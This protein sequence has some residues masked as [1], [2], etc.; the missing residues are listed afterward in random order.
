MNIGFVAQVVPQK[1]RTRSQPARKRPGVG[2]DLPPVVA[3][4]AARRGAHEQVDAPAFGR[5]GQQSEI[6]PGDDVAYIEDAQR[7]D[8]GIGELAEEPVE[9]RRIVFAE[10]AVVEQAAEILPDEE[11][12]RAVFALEAAV[13]QNDGLQGGSVGLDPLHAGRD[14]AGPALQG[15]KQPRQV[16]GKGVGPVPLGVL[17]PEDRPVGTGP[18]AL[19]VD[20]GTGR[21][22]A[23]ASV[24]ILRGKQRHVARLPVNG[25]A[26]GGNAT[27]SSVERTRRLRRGRAQRRSIVVT[28][29]ITLFA[30]HEAVGLDHLEPV[31]GQTGAPDLRQLHVVVAETM[32]QR[33]HRE[34]ELPDA[35]QR[36]GQRGPLLRRDHAAERNH[37]RPPLGCQVDDTLAAGSV[38]KAEPEHGL[39]RHAVGASEEDQRIGVGRRLRLQGKGEFVDV[40]IVAEFKAV[41]VASIR[42]QRHDPRGGRAVGPLRLPDFGSM[43]CRSEKRMSLF[44][45]RCRDVGQLHP[46]VPAPEQRAGKGI[47]AECNQRAARLQKAVQWFGRRLRKERAFGEDEQVES[48]NL[49]AEGLVGEPLDREGFRQTLRQQ[50]AGATVRNIL[51]D[52]HADVQ[53][54]RSGLSAEHP[55]ERQQRDEPHEARRR[56]SV[57]FDSC[58]HP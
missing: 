40:G 19:F 5:A 9:R 49:P 12:R 39:R 17:D 57:S 50:F 30:E 52:H 11:E 15:G 51:A 7:V 54:P 56:D 48:R 35:G 24:A 4:V 2:L 3:A 32:P 26:Q 37:H 29:D 23:A 20:D 6:S 33:R 22:A 10:R 31:F 8:A 44:K 47:A 1:G 42:L 34:G 38:R 43:G 16:V 45:K 46:A 55:E 27:E 25:E 14:K 53:L 13:A 28:V 41:A 58:F 18:R 21:P 36:G